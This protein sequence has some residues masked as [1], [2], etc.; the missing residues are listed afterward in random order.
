ME[1][2][3]S[4][5]I[6]SHGLTDGLQFSILEMKPRVFGWPLFRFG[7]HVLVHTGTIVLEEGRSLGGER[8]RWYCPPHRAS[9]SPGV[10]FGSRSAVLTNAFANC[11]LFF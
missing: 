11:I 9:G 8:G 4:R 3:R 7:V 2:L 5:V 1:H 10:I 6:I